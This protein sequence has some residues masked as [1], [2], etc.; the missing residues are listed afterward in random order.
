[1]IIVFSGVDAS[2][3]STQIE[4]LKNKLS[5]NGFN[6]YYLWSRGGY[7]NGFE[8]IK[9]AVRLIFG[10]KS[11]P[12]GKSTKRD[13][14]MS[15]ILVAR[16]WLMIAMI[17]LFYLYVLKIRFKTLMGNVVLCDRYIGDTF[18]DFSINF[19]RINF[20]KMWLWRLLLITYPKP[21]IG[22]IFVLP[23]EMSM[24]RSKL[25]NEPFPDSKETLAKRLKIYLESDLFNDGV[26]VKI[27]GIESIDST[28]RRIKDKTFTSLSKINA[29]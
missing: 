3:K 22:F 12:S 27:D 8:L 6:F 1:M 21:D 23:I 29:S 17:D 9:K 19:P 13:K 25:K 18:I 11:I 26:W 10:S 15:N 28:S 4:L 2:G 20:E 5:E 16:L 14:A 7:T 24:I